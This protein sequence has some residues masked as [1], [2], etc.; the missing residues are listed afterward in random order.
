MRC[1]DAVFG[2]ALVAGGAAIAIAARD[3]PQLPGQA[4]GAAFFPT[5][6]AYAMGVTGCLLA[7]QGW[8]LRAQQPAIL[9]PPWCRSPYHAASFALVL[10]ALGVYCLVAEAWGFVLTGFALLLALQLWLRVQPLLALAVAVGVPVVLQVLFV[11][12]LRVPLPR[13]LV[14]GWLW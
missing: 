14:E 1:N 2:V 3:F 7:L 5:V 13:G 6:I 12:G 10:G 4:Y 8:R 11:R 9:L